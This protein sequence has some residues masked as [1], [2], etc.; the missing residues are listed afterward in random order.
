M[1]EKVVDRRRCT[2]FAGAAEYLGLAEKTVRSYA[3]PAQR[4]V[5]GF[6]SRSRP[7]GSR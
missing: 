4:P 3:S 2:D 5:A 7:A 1:R 6:G